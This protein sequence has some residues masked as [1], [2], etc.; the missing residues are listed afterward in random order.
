MNPL[1]KTMMK[2][3]INTAISAD[4]DGSLSNEIRE[5]LSLPADTPIDANIILSTLKTRIP[6]EG[7]DM[8]DGREFG[9]M[10]ANTNTVSISN[11]GRDEVTVDKEAVDAAEANTKQDEVEDTTAEKS[12]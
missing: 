10:L 9:E 6:S 5:S 4:P 7:A 2:S 3:M 11:D 1:Q 8:P 12:I